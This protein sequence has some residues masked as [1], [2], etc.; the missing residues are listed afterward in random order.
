MRRLV[1][2]TFINSADYDFFEMILDGDVAVYGKNDAGKSTCARAVLFGEQGNKLDLNFSPGE[3]FDYYLHKGDKEGMLIYDYEESVEDA[4]SVPYCLIITQRSINFVMSRF[5]KSWVVDDAQNLIVDWAGIRTRIEKAEGDVKVYSV[6]SLRNLGY[7]L[8][9][10]YDGSDINMKYLSKRFSLFSGNGK[11]YSASAKIIASLWK[12]GAMGQDEIKRIIIDR[13]EANNTLRM[14][15]EPAFPVDAAR[16]FAADFEDGW[17]DFQRYMSGELKAKMNQICESLGHYESV[18]LDITRY[19]SVTSS[20]YLFK[21]TQLESISS[22]F[23]SLKE[24]LR[25]ELEKQRLLETDI[26]Q[27]RDLRTGEIAVVNDKI[28]NAKAEYNKASKNEWERRKADIKELAN[29]GELNAEIEAVKVIVDKLYKDSE[30]VVGRL[31]ESIKTLEKDKND[32][33]LFKN[34]ELLSISQEK[35][36][37]K[38]IAELNEKLQNVPQEIA[39]FFSKQVF[40]L[41]ET[42]RRLYDVQKSIEKNEEVIDRLSNENALFEQFSSDSLSFIPEGLQRVVVGKFFRA[43][44]VFVCHHIFGISAF[45]EKQLK[46]RKEQYNED[47]SKCK[48]EEKKLKT[49][50]AKKEAE[51]SKNY[52]DQLAAIN[53]EYTQKTQAIKDAISERK[54]NF[55]KQKEQT[56][57]DIAK[58]LESA[59]FNDELL[60]TKEEELSSKRTRL[61]YLTN[62]Q[63]TINQWKA[64][65]DNYLKV[66]EW[67]TIKANLVEQ[68]ISCKQDED[69][70]LDS[71]KTDVANA[72]KV[73]DEQ[74][75]AKKV[76]SLEINNYDSYKEELSRISGWAIE[77]I[78]NLLEKAEPIELRPEELSTLDDYFRKWGIALSERKNDL[79]ALRT[80]VNDLKGM[81]SE[82]D[83][84]NFSI[85]PIDSL[86]SDG[87]Y[88]RVARYVRE[89]NDPTSEN[90]IERYL[91]NWRQNWNQYLRFI[92][93]IAEHSEEI[94]NVEETVRHIESFIRRYNDAHSI[95]RIRFDVFPGSDN[96]LVK[97]SRDIKAILDKNGI[98]VNVVDVSEGVDT[99]LFT[100]EQTTV[101]VRK[102]IVEQMTIF[103]REVRQYKSSEIPPEDFFKIVIRIKEVNKPE[104]EVLTADHLGST[105]TTITLKAILAVGFVGESI[106]SAKTQRSAVHIFVDEFGRID[107]DNKRSI[108]N[109]CEKFNIRLFSAEPSASNDRGDFDYGYSLYYDKLSR[110]RNGKIVKQK[111]REPKTN[112][113]HQ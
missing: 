56:E 66:S 80:F 37:D 74:D 103:S 38:R 88:V 9:D 61:E 31:R 58:A 69:K 86:S 89:R 67:E 112:E 108:S 85:K 50:I 40:T 53:L 39:P 18:N 14:E 84:F 100:L 107:A 32:F 23:D 11:R 42:K 33:I 36:T 24:A 1:K 13:T 28:N 96:I 95:E 46:E 15:R 52:T 16:N 60:K 79:A 4:P 10:S 78:D 21:K 55:D 63:E 43:V 71:V 5:S 44:F 92:V 19:P 98:D 109:M 110:Y 99:S 106:G 82:Q 75:K 73:L 64:V 34:E 2:I 70:Q 87:D 90:Y 25:L 48:A 111:K 83:F 57:N 27:K 72:K 93:K 102:Q 7:I 94:S 47:A 105:G 30:S 91:N 26:T 77:N 22:R 76:I 20:A 62:N 45:S 113:E 12:N 49:D 68:D 6:S 51:L 3:S 59:G 65:L 101:Q 97:T 29:I 17:K 54:F 104:I 35:E 41:N 81:L 8:Q